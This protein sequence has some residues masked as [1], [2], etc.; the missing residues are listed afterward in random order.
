MPKVGPR[1]EAENTTGNRDGRLLHAVGGGELIVHARRRCPMPAGAAAAGATTVLP[2]TTNHDN[3]MD[4]RHP[5]PPTPQTKQPTQKAAEQP[6]RAPPAAATTWR[7]CQRDCQPTQQDEP[8][9]QTR[10]PKHERPQNSNQPRRACP[11][12][13]LLSPSSPRR[14]M[15]TRP[16]SPAALSVELNLRGPAVDHGAGPDGHHSRV[17]VEHALRQH[18][19]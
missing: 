7:D 17:G 14:P 18:R 2:A 19:L 15:H 16:A 4:T 10:Q 12:E 9:P 11:A 6:P 5:P 13:A 1:K 8:T 3:S